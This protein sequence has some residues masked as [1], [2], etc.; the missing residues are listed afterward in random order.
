MADNS[1]LRQE[2]KRQSRLR[3]K[4]TTIQIN[5]DNKD[6]IKRIQAELGFASIDETID[7]IV[8]EYNYVQQN[9]EGNKNDSD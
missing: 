8:S 3:N 1:K 2:Q 6:K 7:E 5:T 9:R 4:K